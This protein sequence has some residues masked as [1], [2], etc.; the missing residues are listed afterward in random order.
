MKNGKIIIDDKVGGKTV[1]VGGGG[2]LTSRISFPYM[3]ED[4]S[5]QCYLFALLQINWSRRKHFKSVKNKP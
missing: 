2:V 3:S 5:Y 4:K 1:I